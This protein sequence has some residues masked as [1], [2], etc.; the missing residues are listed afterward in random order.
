MNVLLQCYTSLLAENDIL[1]MLSF[2]PCFVV[3]ENLGVRVVCNQ[4]TGGA[5]A[6]CAYTRC[7]ECMSYLV[8]TPD[9]TREAGSGE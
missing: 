4:D 7:V 1:H 8:W 5:E 3:W 6:K 9:P 2:V